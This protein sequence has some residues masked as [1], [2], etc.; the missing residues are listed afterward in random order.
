[1]LLLCFLNI[2]SDIFSFFPK[3]FFFSIYY[4]L[5]IF[6]SLACNSVLALKRKWYEAPLPSVL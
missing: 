1:M 5:L 6:Y 3:Y 4:S 2:F